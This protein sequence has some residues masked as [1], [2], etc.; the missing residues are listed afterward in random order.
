MKVNPSE[1]G[2][3]SRLSRVG[4]FS[5]ALTFRSLYYPSAKM[6]T[7][8][9]LIRG[10][11]DSAVMRA[12][13][14]HQCGPGT[15]P[16]VHAIYGLNLLLVLSFASRGFS[17]STPVFPSPQKPTFPTIR[18]GIHGHVSAS[19]YELLSA[20][21]VNIQQITICSKFT[22]TMEMQ[23]SSLPTRHLVPPKLFL[24]RRRPY[25]I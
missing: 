24:W 15:N 16:A 12:L 1:K 21:W 3:A 19:S 22:I 9:S 17:P 5:R 6:R 23:V 11:R 2:A 14:S 18:S 25:V 10:A 8:R 20:P 7:T 13:A 4:W